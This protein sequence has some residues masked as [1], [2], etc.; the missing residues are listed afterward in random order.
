[1]TVLTGVKAPFELTQYAIAI[2]QQGIDFAIRHY[3]HQAGKSLS[4]AEA[5]ALTDAG[6]QIGVVW[7]TPDAHLSYFSRAQG[8][9]DGAAAYLMAQ[10]VIAQPSGS[11]VYFAVD[12]HPGEAEIAGPVTRYFEG[13]NQAFGAASAAERQY[14]VG[15]YGSGAC[16]AAMM[17][18]G[19]ASVSWL[20]DETEDYGG[21][22]LRQLDAAVLP[23][24]DG[25]RIS[26][27]MACNSPERPAGLFRVL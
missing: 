19:L 22:S 21:Y 24:D 8:C 16:C 26:V 17:A 11:A 18:Q 6:I 23:V 4:L 7:E 27:R 3:T 20:A 15:V 13:V 1:M 14:Q 25:Q 9:A 2:K 5:R 12:F 10:S